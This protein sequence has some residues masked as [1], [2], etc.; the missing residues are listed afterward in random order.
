MCFSLKMIIQSFLFIFTAS[1]N[2]P[3]NGKNGYCKKDQSVC[4]CVECLNRCKE[5][6]EKRFEEAKKEKDKQKDKKEMDMS[7]IDE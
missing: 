1:N 6:L 5:Q 3:T 7:D 2:N 4:I